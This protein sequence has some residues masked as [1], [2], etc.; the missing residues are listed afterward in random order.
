M[1]RKEQ[2]RRTFA[3]KYY[4]S[5]GA[6]SYREGRYSSAVRYFRKALAIEDLPYIRLHLGLSYL[7]KSNFRRAI[8][9]M[10][11]A[12]G[13]APTEAEYYYQRSNAW[14]LMGNVG[15]ADEDLAAAIR[16][17]PNYGRIGAI[18]AA[19]SAL[20]LVFGRKEEDEKPDNAGVQ[21]ESL[22][23]V[24]RA[25]DRREAAKRR[26]VEETSCPVAACPAYCCHFRG[27]PVLHGLWIGPWKLQAIRRFISVKRLTEDD[28]L[29]KGPVD[30]DQER[31]HLIPPHVIVK[32]RGERVVFHPKASD[33][34]LAHSLVSAL[35]RTIDYRELSWITAE[36]RACA[37]LDEGRC[38]IHD[39]GGESALPAC[40]EF[41]CLTGY[42][43]LVLDRIGLRVSELMKSFS[44]KELNGIA[45]DAL[46]SLHTR[47]YGND[48]L[49]RMEDEML[50]AL[51]AAR[52]ADAGSDT[53]LV[54]EA[55]D[56]YRKLRIR[57]GRRFSRQKKLLEKDVLAFFGEAAKR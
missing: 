41:F 19:A 38:M 8:T 10:T 26:T 4:H 57:H 27:E 25:A 33:R 36:A 2:L 49:K 32:D 7:R 42:V 44:V 22:R 39:L 35:P 45:V 21:D 1:D 37:F 28:F 16:L 9:E 52:E 17:D 50:A 46:L 43:F 23:A 51:Y 54:A 30:S 12:I 31:Y 6:E 48:G 13:L 29:A 15:R 24:L 3:E 11:K 14:R 18:R 53:R 40:K 20:Q 34:P 55:V 56:R 47:L 5:R